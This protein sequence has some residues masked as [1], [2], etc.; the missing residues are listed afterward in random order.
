MSEVFSGKLIDCLIEIHVHNFGETVDRI[1]G[2]SDIFVVI[3]PLIAVSF[4]TQSCDLADIIIAAF[5]I[6]IRVD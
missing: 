1:V 4:Q 2:A 5:L 6:C 3:I